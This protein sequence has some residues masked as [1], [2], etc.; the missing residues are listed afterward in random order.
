[1]L[2]F[3]KLE[4]NFQTKCQ[5]IA[6]HLNFGWK[7]VKNGLYINYIPGGKIYIL[8]EDKLY[9]GWTKNNCLIP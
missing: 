1:M 2:R 5:N 7:K 9:K 3:P 8:T 4:S 6:H